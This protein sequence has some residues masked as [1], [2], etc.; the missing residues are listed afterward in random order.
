MPLEELLAHLPRLNLMEIDDCDFVY[1]L[2]ERARIEWGV[3]TSEE[4]Y[5]MGVCERELVFLDK[6]QDENDPFVFVNLSNIRKY[7]RL[8]VYPPGTK[9]EIL[10]ETLRVI[11]PA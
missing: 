5:V 4:A 9:I 11:R 3:Y 10:D 2:A 8:E 7:E 6:T 1:G